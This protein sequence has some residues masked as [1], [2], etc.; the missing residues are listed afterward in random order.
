MICQRIRLYLC[1][2]YLTK[3]I[4]MINIKKLKG[5][6]H[7]IFDL[8]KESG[9]LLVLLIFVDVTFMLIHVFLYKMQAVDDPHLLNLL[10]IEIDLGYSE[11]FQY[12]KEYWIA[13]LLLIFALKKKHIIYFS[14]SLLFLYFLFD[15][16]L[17]IHEK[18]GESLVNHFN[19]QPMF[20]L[21]ANDLGELG[22]SLFF[23]SFLFSFIAI[24]YYFSDS[25]AKKIS[26]DLFI[27]VLSVAFFGV[28]IDML[29]MIVPVAGKA[30]WGLIEDGGEMIIM[31]FIVW[32]VFKIK[33]TS[34]KSSI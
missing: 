22:V 1:N 8:E 10:S 31:S 20:G 11:I 14:W 27:G 25:V 12:I 34:K 15:D 21:R 2:C 7:E 4:I 23:A 5:K 6:F 30:L 9:R 16:S 13:L 26:K 17:Q 24:A 18:L 32:Y 19:V 28:V 29:H 33:L 3:T